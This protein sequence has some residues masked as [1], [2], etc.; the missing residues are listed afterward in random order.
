MEYAPTTHPPLTQRYEA[1]RQSLYQPFGHVYPLSPSPSPIT[2]CIPVVHSSRNTFRV[3][4]SPLNHPTSIPTDAPFYD[5]THHS[6]R[7]VHS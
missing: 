5:S 7:V 4:C 1:H 2:F 3:V 6:V